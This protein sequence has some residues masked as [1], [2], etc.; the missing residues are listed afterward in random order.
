MDKKQLWLK[1]KNYHFNHVVPLHLGDRINEIFGGVDASTK[2]FASKIARKAGW[3]NK[4][5]LKALFEYKKFVFLGVVSDFNVT[6]S[7]IID[8]V[9][10]EHLLFTNAYRQFCNEVIYYT[11]DH[12]PELIPMT[13]QT[14]NFNDQYIRT[15]ELYKNEFG[16]EPPSEIWSI[17]KFDQQKV[18]TGEDISRK[19]K[20]YQGSDT[21]YSDAPLVSFFGDS[22]DGNSAE[23]FS[24]FDG[25]GGGDSGGGGAGGDWGDGNSDS[26]S[27]SDSGG[28]SSGCGGG[29]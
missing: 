24:N 7:K 8:Q 12:N 23:S 1:L 5:A 20:Y 16:N 6:P 17:P 22:Q 27:G 19:K 9:W 25:F 21:T 3:T 4:F 18:I 2:A 13:D 15:I 14:G 28:C 29:D 11:F 10:H 26:S